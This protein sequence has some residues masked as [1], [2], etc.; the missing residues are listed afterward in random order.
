MCRGISKG[1]I[2]LKY[3][4]NSSKITD[5]RHLYICNNNTRISNSWY[6]TKENNVNGTQ[7]VIRAAT[8]E[9]LI[10]VISG[11]I[12]TKLICSQCLCLYND[13]AFK[14]AARA[15]PSDTPSLSQTVKMQA[16]IIQAQRRTIQQLKSRL[17][18]SVKESPAIDLI[19]GHIVGGDLSAALSKLKGVLNHIQTT[20][21]FESFEGRLSFSIDILRSLELQ[22]QGKTRKGHAYLF[23]TKQILGSLRT[24]GQI[25][26]EKVA[27]N[28]CLATERTARNWN[29]KFPRFEIGFSD[30]NFNTVAA[31]YKDL[32]AQYGIEHDV[33][34]FFAEDETVIIPEPDWDERDDCIIGFCGKKC[35]MGCE[36]SS[37][38]CAI[39]L[40]HQCMIDAPKVVVGSED[41]GYENIK[42]AKETMVVSTHA[43]VIMINPMHKRLP[44]LVCFLVGT[45][46]RFKE[47]DYV[48]PQWERL[49]SLFD[50]HVRAVVGPLIGHAS[51]GDSRRRKAFR[52]AMLSTKV[53]DGQLRYGLMGIK[54][55]TH[56]GL[57]VN[58]I[59]TG[60]MDQ[61]YLHNFKK[62]INC[63]DNPGRVLTLGSLGVAHIN[64]L[65]VLDQK[66]NLIHGVRASDVVRNGFDKTD[67]PSAQRIVSKKVITYL[68]ELINNGNKT[69]LASL[70][71]IK[72]CR[73]YLNIFLSTKMTLHERI[74]SAGYIVTYLRAWR[75]WVSKKKD[76][77]MNK[78]CPPRET[79]EDVI[80]SCHM[81]VLLIMAQRDICKGTNVLLQ[82]SGSDCVE[83][84]FSSLGS[85]ILNMRNYKLQSA[86]QTIQSLIVES[87]RKAAGDLESENRNKRLRSVWDDDEPNDPI[88]DMSDI[89]DDDEISRL[90]SDGVKEAKTHCKRDGLNIAKICLEKEEIDYGIKTDNASETGTTGKRK[91]GGKKVQANAVVVRLRAEEKAEEVT[92]E[93]K[94]EV[95]E[96]RAGDEAEK[97]IKFD[98][99]TD[100]VDVALD[101]MREGSSFD[102][103]VYVEH[104]TVSLHKRAVINTLFKGLKLSN[105]RLTRIRNA[106]NTDNL[107]DIRGDA[108]SINVHGDIAVLYFGD[109]NRKHMYFGRVKRIR[110]KINNKYIEYRN[111]VV[112]GDTRPTDIFLTIQYYYNDKRIGSNPKEHSDNDRILYFSNEIETEVYLECVICPVVITQLDQDAN[113][114]NGYFQFEVEKS[115]YNTAKIALEDKEYVLDSLDSETIDSN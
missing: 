92:E 61:D 67:V 62:L 96:V 57:V 38:N 88:A 20:S 79:C 85:W 82:R 74:H 97:G 58:G 52:E 31:I 51:D 7:L 42:K 53:E 49:R 41:D 4:Q 81:A 110:R 71:Y 113:H 106:E 40:R 11:T 47:D 107:W 102:S 36:V 45:C 55:F 8:C 3:G 28:L 89:P 30:S 39:N 63:F 95:A 46:L 59:P 87:M 14:R 25:C 77:D 9:R 76:L 60:I 1:C 15:S 86:R 17:N 33:P 35:A 12:P 16:I 93:T 32:K 111:P 100:I 73:S 80:L 66:D 21:T 84:L 105:D 75:L 90:W 78:H 101:I 54:D 115:S 44:A 112:I 91:R 13:K 18:K 34:C 65:R 72:L 5:I 83:A 70:T 10:Q 26:Y 6:C 24:S 64:D 103:K 50:K 69:L 19:K 99:Y 29:Y 94:A 48:K 109:G 22:T 98:V 43:R 114:A 27:H 37:C 104:L 68:E 2:T 56:T 108:W 23:H